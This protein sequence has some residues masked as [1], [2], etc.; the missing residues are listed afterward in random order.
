MVSLSRQTQ[1]FHRF[2]SY[3]IP[4]PILSRFSE[5]YVGLPVVN[6]VEINLHK[7]KI[8]NIIDT[9]LYDSSRELYLKNQINKLSKTLK[10]EV[11]LD[12]VEKLY[13]KGYSGLDIIK[14]IEFDKNIND[15]DKYTLLAMLSKVKSDFRNEKI[16]MFWC[17]IFGYFRS[18]YNLENI[19]FI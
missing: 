2:Y 7:Y 8:E 1:I 12:L 11:L 6:N 13:Q 15:L 19:S 17:I 18:E 14:H 10:V 16:L 3:I 4:R 5:I 9:K